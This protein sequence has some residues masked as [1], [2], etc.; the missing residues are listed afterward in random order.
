MGSLCGAWNSEFDL[1]TGS[2]R[3]GPVL[4][5]HVQGNQLQQEAIEAGVEDELEVAKLA[6][7]RAQGLA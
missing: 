4:G 5:P 7:C 2:R 3:S 1:G 6:L